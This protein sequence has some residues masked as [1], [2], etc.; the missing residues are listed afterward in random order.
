MDSPPETAP[1]SF[2]DAVRAE[3]ARIARELVW[4]H[5]APDPDSVAISGIGTISLEEFDR[6]I[7]RAR[8]DAARAREREAEQIDREY[9]DV[10]GQILQSARGR[11]PLPVALVRRGPRCRGA[12]RPAHRRSAR[13]TSRAGPSDPDEPEPPR[14]RLSLRLLRNDREPRRA[15]GLRCSNDPGRWSGRR[16][17]RDDD[18]VSRQ[19]R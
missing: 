6:R 14:R 18:G 3:E 5:I 8:R 11:M 13:A 15:R 2:E 1:D 12:G 7:D 10:Y 17:E 16:K 9:W 4:A 19:Q